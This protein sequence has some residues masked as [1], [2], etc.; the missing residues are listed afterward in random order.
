MKIATVRSQLSSSLVA[1]RNVDGS[2]TNAINPTAIDPDN[3]RLVRMK[4]I[5][6]HRLFDGRSLAEGSLIIDARG[7]SSCVRRQTLLSHARCR[8][9]GQTARAQYRPAPVAS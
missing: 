9:A 2:R 3:R 5:A 4:R 7:A 1:I 8:R 6:R